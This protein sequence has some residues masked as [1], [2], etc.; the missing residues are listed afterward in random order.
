MMPFRLLASGRLDSPSIYIPGHVDT[1]RKSTVAYRQCG[2]TD[3]ND[4]KSE[5]PR[6]VKQQ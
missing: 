2:V 3:P 6:S 5:S 4:K 1:K